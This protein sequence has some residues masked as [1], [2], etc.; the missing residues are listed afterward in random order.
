M[1]YIRSLDGSMALMSKLLRSGN[2]VLDLLF[3]P[4][5]AGCRVE[6]SYLCGACMAKARR[7]ETAFHPPTRTAETRQHW[8]GLS[9]AMP[10][11]AP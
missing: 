10:W 11:R 1:A 3:T 9:P 6:G 7:L 4:R 2:A 8:K 5:C